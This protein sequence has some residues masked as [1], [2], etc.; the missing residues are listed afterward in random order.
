MENKYKLGKKIPSKRDSVL[1]KDFLIIPPISPMVDLAPN[2]DYP[3]FGNDLWGDCVSADEG[4]SQQVITGLLNGSMYT[5]TIQQI[6]TWYETQNPN[7]TPTSG[8][9]GN[10][11]DIQ[12]FL[13]YL[14]T[15][16]I[17]LGFAKIDFH[18]TS[19]FQAAIYLGL[20][21][22]VGVQ[23]QQ[24]QQGKQFSDGLWDFVLGS[25]IVGGH[26][27]CFVGY[28]SIT[29]RYQ[30]ISW[31]KLI[32]CT[33]S[34]VD[35]LVDEAWIPIRQ[36]HVDHPGFRNNFDLAGFSKAVSDLTGGKVTIPVPAP[37]VLPPAPHP[38]LPSVTLVRN[39]D[40]GIETL[41]TLTTDDNQF[42]CR[43]LERSWKNN[44]TNISCIPKGTYI[45]S[46][47]F[48]LRELKYRYQV[49]NVPKRTGI[50]FHLG[51][52]FFNSAGCILLG[53][54]PQD[55]NSDKQLDLINSGSITT[56]FE[57]KM[58]KKDFILT[59]Q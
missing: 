32:E 53:S 23:L 49:L 2:Y 44:Q 26:D 59:I 17:I 54:L 47:R 36:E 5:P 27:I 8:D 42:Q 12:I 7:W 20:S 14:I 3:M 58:G 39:V 25:P 33:Q 30:L 37:T 13:E 29:K 24:A 40:N 18:N 9:E 38:I 35:N 48:M 56:S 1:F 45:V 52:F 55:I 19:L 10:G 6:E 16:K 34:F 43:T 50:F 21:I 28:N 22:K 41:G 46:W 51:N 4:H 15:Q 57:T 31:G 11:M